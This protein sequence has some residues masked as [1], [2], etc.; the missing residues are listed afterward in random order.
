[1]RDGTR[2]DVI[3]N[4]SQPSFAHLVHMRAQGGPQQESTEQCFIRTVASIGEGK[5]YTLMVVLPKRQRG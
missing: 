1:M 5:K 2:L 3:L 4:Y